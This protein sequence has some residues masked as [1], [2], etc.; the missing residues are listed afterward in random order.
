MH[1]YASTHDLSRL[2]KSQLNLHAKGTNKSKQCIA[3]RTN[4]ALGNPL[5]SITAVPHDS[6]LQEVAL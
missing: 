5:D 2:E 1:F 6:N 3:S 4:A